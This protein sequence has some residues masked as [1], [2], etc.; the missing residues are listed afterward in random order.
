[1]EQTMTKPKSTPAEITE[2]NEAIDDQVRGDG[3]AQRKKRASRRLSVDMLPAAAGVAVQAEDQE[4]GETE[5][6][7]RRA[8]D[9]RR[10]GKK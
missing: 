8:T 9:D 1:M 3:D 2:T 5:A 4:G 6:A 7:L 10:G